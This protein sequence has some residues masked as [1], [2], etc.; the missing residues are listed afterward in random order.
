MPF[1]LSCVFFD[2]HIHSSH[3]LLAILHAAARVGGGDGQGF[4]P[5]IWLACECSA[6]GSIARTGLCWGVSRVGFCLARLLPL[7]L[8][9]FWTCDCYFRV[10]SLVLVPPFLSFLTN[11][12]CDPSCPHALLGSPAAAPGRNRVSHGSTLPYIDSGPLR[13]APTRRCP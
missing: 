5:A 4:D 3:R 7:L 11:S 10:C 1:R 6:T 9:S 2:L 13:R 12:L 8:S